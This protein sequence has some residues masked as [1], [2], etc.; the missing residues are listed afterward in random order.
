MTQQSTP[1][2]SRRSL[3]TSGGALA[4]SGVVLAACGG[5]HSTVTRLGTAPEIAPL[6]EAHVT[7]VVLL[8]T[9]MSMETMIA[10]IMLEPKLLALTDDAT[11]PVVEA[12]AAAHKSHLAPLSSLITARGGEPYTGTNEKLMNSYGQNIID[13]IAE[14]KNKTDVPHLAVALEALTA[15]TYQFF[16]SMTSEPALR[17]EMMKL[18]VTSA[19]RAAVVSQ[20]VTPGT[21]AFAQKLDEVGSP[22]LDKDGN[23]VV[24]TLPSA[25]GLLS[26]VQVTLGPVN[27]ES[28][29]RQS[30]LLDTPSLNSLIY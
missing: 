21:G 12:F 8:R 7:D 24:A 11:K 5:S 15:A 26:S 14:G 30:I 6:E 3:L 4:A 1:R 23:P 19:R 18:G 9:A 16:V 10:N 2:I 17:A 25:F 29:T 27:P 28:G 20:L 13:L 22:I